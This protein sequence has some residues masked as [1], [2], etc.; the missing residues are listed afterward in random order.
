MKTVRR[1]KLLWANAAIVVVLVAVAIVWTHWPAW[2]VELTRRSLGR[3][4]GRSYGKLGPTVG[5]EPPAP[6]PRGRGG[7]DFGTAL[8]A[9]RSTSPAL[10]LMAATLHLR[11]G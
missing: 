7:G 2:H 11:V 1:R 8:H 5:S 9:S 6:W 3:G 10:L 4:G